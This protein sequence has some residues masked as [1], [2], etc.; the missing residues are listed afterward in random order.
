MEQ[1]SGA[2]L[3]RF[4]KGGKKSFLNLVKGELDHKKPRKIERRKKPG[5]RQW[6]KRMRKGALGFTDTKDH[7]PE[8]RG[9]SSVGKKKTEKR[10]TKNGKKKAPRIQ[11]MSILLFLYP[12]LKDTK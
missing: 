5:S 3:K 9:C 7:F 10:G 11:T 12:N 1:D 8:R 2:P 6:G 4:E